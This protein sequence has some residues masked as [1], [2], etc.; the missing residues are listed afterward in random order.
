MRPGGRARAILL[1]TGKRTRYDANTG[2]I[3]RRC[4]GRRYLSVR[5]SEHKKQMTLVMPDT[6]G[7]GDIRY[8]RSAI[9]MMAQ[10]KPIRD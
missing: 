6:S 5:D 10:P 3:T 1:E 9:M 8:G 2:R 7:M 4:M